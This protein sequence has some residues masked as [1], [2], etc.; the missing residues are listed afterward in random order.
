MPPPPPLRGGG[1]ISYNLDGREHKAYVFDVVE[2]VVIGSCDCH[3]TVADC[4]F[5]A[6]V[7]CLAVSPQQLFHR[8]VPLSQHFHEKYAGNQ[9]FS[10]L[11][12]TQ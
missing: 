11:Y 5:V 8:V 9:S 6:A 4:W 1:I 2:L 7:G 12:H 10:H 3:V